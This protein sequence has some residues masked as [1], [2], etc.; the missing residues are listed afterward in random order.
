MVAVL[1]G[2]CLPCVLGDA[3]SISSVLLETPLPSDVPLAT[4]IAPLGLPDSESLKG[5]E[6]QDAYS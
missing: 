3:D 1:S 5:K 6:Q 4:V 2:L